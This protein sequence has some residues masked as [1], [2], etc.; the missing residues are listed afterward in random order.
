M[1]L[2]HSYGR[3]FWEGKSF[4]NSPSKHI[5][6]IIIK[7]QK[8]REQLAIKAQSEHSNMELSENYF[9]WFLKFFLQKIS[10]Y[11]VYL[12][13]S[14]RQQKTKVSVEKPAVACIIIVCICLSYTIVVYCS[15][16]G[17]PPVQQNWILTAS[18]I[19]QYGSFEV[20]KVGLMY[21]WGWCSE[22]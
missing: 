20:N 13:L 4:G 22:W 16:A 12:T 18:L 6:E 5:L 3:K 19:C 14:S 21:P 15:L 17:C 1:I 2:Y 9:Q 8:S 10:H 7:F 11:L